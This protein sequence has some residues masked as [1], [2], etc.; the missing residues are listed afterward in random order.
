MDERA[1]FISLAHANP[2]PLDFAKAFVPLSLTSSL[3]GEVLKTLFRLG[4]SFHQQVELPDISNLNWQETV[5]RCLESLRSR[6]GVP[7][8]VTSTYLSNGYGHTYSLVYPRA[9]KWASIS[10]DLGAKVLDPS[11]TSVW[12]VLKSAPCLPSPPPSAA[13]V[14]QPPMANASL[15]PAALPNPPPFAAHVSPPSVANPSPSVVA[16]PSPVSALQQR[17]PEPAPRQLP[18]VPAPRMRFAVPAPPERPP[19]PA[20][21]M[22]FAVPALPECPKETALPERPKRP[23][24]PSAPKSPRFQGAPK[25]L[26][27]QRAPQSPLH[28]SAHQ[29]PLHQ[30]AHQSPV[31]QRAHQRAHQSLLLLSGSQRGTSLIFF[32]GGAIYPWS[33]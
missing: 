24:F 2:E 6:A 21:R 14:R 15:P 20:P 25:S 18:L 8:E 11:L 33:G 22:R 12:S 13:N 9:R 5:I 10:A 3:E 26:R 28:Q 17:P 32:L 1:L 27:I 4:I 7:S 31:H 29:N 30:R 16:L 19:V 23:R